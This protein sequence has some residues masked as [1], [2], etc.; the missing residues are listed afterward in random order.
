MK[1]DCKLSTDFY[2]GLVSLEK[3][4]DAKSTAMARFGIKKSKR[5]HYNDVMDEVIKIL[6]E[7]NAVTFEDE[8]TLE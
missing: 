8:F 4:K 3:Y 7:Y 1:S 2:L 5:V 6:I